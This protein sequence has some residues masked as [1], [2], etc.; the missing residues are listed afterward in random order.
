MCKCKKA[1]KALD[2]E[3]NNS[4]VSVMINVTDIVKYASLASVAIVGIIFAPKLLREF[5]KANKKEEE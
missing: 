2:K 1:V 4:A 5:S 3:Q